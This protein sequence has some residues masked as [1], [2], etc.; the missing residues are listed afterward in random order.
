M[1]GFRYSEHKVLITA[2]LSFLLTGSAVQ[3]QCDDFYVPREGVFDGNVLPSSPDNEGAFSY[4]PRYLGYESSFYNFTLW[5]GCLTGDI[6][7]HAI[8]LRNPEGPNNTTHTSYF[9]VATDVN[10]M[11]VVELL[12]ELHKRKHWT[13]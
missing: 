12:S 9:L 7:T 2:L 11:T 1:L 5:C 4:Q 10:T 13:S 8:A 3:F 6:S